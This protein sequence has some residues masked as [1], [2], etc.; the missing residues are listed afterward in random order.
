MT[1]LELSFTYDIAA[2]RDE[3]AVESNKLRREIDALRELLTAKE[4][5]LAEHQ[6]IVDRCNVMLDFN[7]GMTTT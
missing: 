6:A 5:E 4:G 2:K 3:H 1:S 7:R